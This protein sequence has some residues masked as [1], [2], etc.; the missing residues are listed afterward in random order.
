MGKK[1]TL[2]LLQLYKNDY[3]DL[4]S[5]T[6]RNDCIYNKISEELRSEGCYFSKQQVKDRVKYLK[7]RY[8]RWKD[9][10]KKSGA[11]PLHFE[12]G[13]LMDEILGDK[14]NVTPMAVV[15]TTDH[16][17]DTSSTANEAAKPLHAYDVTSGVRGKLGEVVTES[18]ER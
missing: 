12:Y 15:D 11:V 17:D 16:D 2:A 4:M 6:T 1:E 8:M 13:A 5:T 14:P 3:Q 10:L 7:M 9:N 18:G